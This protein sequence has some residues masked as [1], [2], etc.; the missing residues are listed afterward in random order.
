MSRLYRKA[1]LKL[2]SE[3]VKKA[4]E[5][6]TNLRYEAHTS[7]WPAHLTSSLHVRVTPEGHYM[8]RYP[9]DLEHDI[10]TLEYGTEDT[11]PSPVMRN[12]FTKIGR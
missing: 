6:T 2:H 11:P 7:G 4:R 8:I 12:Y 3:I 9:K 10:L 1:A 5:H